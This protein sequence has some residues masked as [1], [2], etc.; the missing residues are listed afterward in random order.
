VCHSFVVLLA[1]LTHS[2]PSRITIH[3]RPVETGNPNP[4]LS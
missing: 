4:I 3:T 1:V 2:L